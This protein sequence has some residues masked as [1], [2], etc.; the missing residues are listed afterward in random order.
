MSPDCA[1]S[2]DL[3]FGL[4]VVASVAVLA[5]ALLAPTLRGAHGPPLAIEIPVSPLLAERRV[6]RP[7]PTIA[8]VAK[9]SRRTVAAD[10]RIPSKPIVPVR[11]PRQPDDATA[12]EPSITLGACKAASSAILS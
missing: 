2:N 8:C 4:Q 9:R 6:I 5:D 12:A 11:R 1:T 7:A 10:H 3:D